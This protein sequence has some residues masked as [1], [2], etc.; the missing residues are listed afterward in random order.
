VYRIILHVGYK[1]FGDLTDFKKKETPIRS[2][3]PLSAKHRESHSGDLLKRLMDQG[4][5]AEAVEAVKNMTIPPKDFPLEEAVIAGKLDFMSLFI[6]NGAPLERNAEENPYL[7]LAARGSLLS[8][9][10]EKNRLTFF[11]PSWPA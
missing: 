8:F 2:I 11:D 6:E 1:H 4:K 7:V 5:Y 3:S 10:C 9:Q